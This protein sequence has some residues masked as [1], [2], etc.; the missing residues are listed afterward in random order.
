MMDQEE[1][2]LYELLASQIGQIRGACSVME[3]TLKELRDHRSLDMLEGSGAATVYNQRNPLWA[4][5]KLGTSS[6]TIGG[7]GCLI[8][9]VASMLTDAGKVMNPLQL[10]D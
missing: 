5:A 7:Y 4:A 9:C 6:S 3:N 1:I 10:N 8:S 2:R